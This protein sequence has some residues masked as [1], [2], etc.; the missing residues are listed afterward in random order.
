MKPRA[1]R[2]KWDLIILRGKTELEYSLSFESYEREIPMMS[3]WTSIDWRLD[4]SQVREE[5]HDILQL[6]TLYSIRKKFV[7]EDFQRH[8]DPLLRT[9]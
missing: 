6:E 4:W 3:P 1:N 5:N 7:A 8:T 9:Y 2:E